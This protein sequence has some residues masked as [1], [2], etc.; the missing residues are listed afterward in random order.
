V[1]HLVGQGAY[2]DGIIDKASGFDAYSLNDDKASIDPPAVSL[3]NAESQ[4]RE[5]V[6]CSREA[7]LLPDECHR[8][9]EE[10][11]RYHTEE[12]GG[13]WSTVRDSSVKTTDVAVED[14]P[15]LRLWLLALLQSR[16]YPVIDTLFPLLGDGTTIAPRSAGGWWLELH[17]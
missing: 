16:L 6:F 13:K 14:I 4:K 17:P 11:E 5:L 15:V 12:L 9:V 3:F 7:L 1:E 2:G 10:V 8:V